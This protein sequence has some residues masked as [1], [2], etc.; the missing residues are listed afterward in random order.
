MNEVQEKELNVLREII[1]ICDQYHLTYYAI[2]GTCLGAVRHK[3]FIPWDDDI[4]IGMPRPDY[5]FFRTRLYRE[6]P[7][8]I[9]KLDCDMTSHHAFLFTKV[10]DSRTTFIENYAAGMTERYTGAYVDI[11][12]VDGFPDDEKEQKKILRKQKLRA[13]LNIRVRPTRRAMT[14]M[15]RIK[16][17][18]KAV[19][20]SALRLFFTYSHFSDKILCEGLKTD[21]YDSPYCLFTWRCDKRYPDNKRYFFNRSWFTETVEMPFEDLMIKVPGGYDSYLKRDYGDYMTVPKEEKQVSVHDVYVLDMEKPCS[22]Y[23]QRD[24]ETGKSRG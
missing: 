15:D 13:R 18:V 20:R 22:F 21:Y 1:R 16:N 7:E 10:H 3:G 24:R 12:P 8:W 4:D 17:L 6:L 2:G 14:P 11:M 5:E 19:I 23:A 9:H